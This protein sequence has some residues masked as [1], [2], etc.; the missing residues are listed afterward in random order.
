MLVKVFNNGKGDGDIMSKLDNVIIG[1]NHQFIYQEAMTDADAHTRTL[2]MLVNNP[3]VDALDCWVW[4]AHSKEELA[5]LKNGKKHINY[6]IGDRIGEVPVFPATADAKERAYALDMLKRETNFAVESGAKKIIF[7]SGK[8]VLDGREDAMKRFEEFVLMWSEF[9]PKDVWLT[10]EPTDRDVDK[11]FLY[12]SM[13]ETCE[14][15]RNIR[16][17]GMSNMGILLDMGHI[18]IMH[19]TL[20]SA[21]S[22][23]GELLEHIHLGNCVI[24][25]PANMYYGDKHP[26]WGFEDGEYD[27]KDGEEFLK[28]LLQSG[29][30]TRGNDRTV[31]FEMRPLVGKTSEETIEYLVKWFQKAYGQL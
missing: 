27:E 29:Y 5:I 18:P 19:E 28:C 20:Q 23:G 16:N 17:A 10:L 12:G 8:D 21:T 7:G 9:I 11:Y 13:A 25:N 26:C 3:N 1:I 2:E 15:I 14:T 31:S 24:K 22:T 6:N 4:A 30:F